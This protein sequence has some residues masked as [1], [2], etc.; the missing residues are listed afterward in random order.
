MIAVRIGPRLRMA[1]V[2]S[3]AYFAR[4]GKP[5]TPH[6]LA[7][8]SCINLRMV[9]GSIYA[10]EFEKDGR[11]LKVKVE[12]QLTFNDVELILAA[13]VAGKGIAF[14]VED[15]AAALLAE[16]ALVRVLRTGASRSTA[17][18]STIPAGGSHRQP[19]A[20]FWKVCASENKASTAPPSAARRRA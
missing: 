6:D 14:L 4:R 11:G 1:A 7:G 10:W 19:S 9:S 5:L 3:P 20:C 18:T 12:G 15:R 2:G 8:H 13:A 16:G 17:I